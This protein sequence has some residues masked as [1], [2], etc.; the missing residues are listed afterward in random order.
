[1]LLL[2]AVAAVIVALVVLGTGP[3][4]APEL[5]EEEARPAPASVLE[6]GGTPA[7]KIS[8]VRA[9]DTDRSRDERE[10]PSTVLWPLEVGLELVRPSLLPSVPS[11]PPLG[12]G[13]TARIAGRIADSNGVGAQAELEFV[14]GP[15][16]GRVLTTGEDGR[17][18]ANDLYPGLEVVEVRGPRILGSRRE[19]RLRENKSFE[20]NIGYG[21]PGGAQGRVV[22]EQGKPIVGATVTVDGRAGVTDRT[23]HF[24]VSPVASGHSVLLEI[25]HPDYASHRAEIGVALATVAEPRR[26]LYTLTR[27][28]TLRLVLETDIG[29][30]EPALVHV[31]PQ[32]GGMNRDYPWYRLNPVQVGTEPVELTGLPAGPLELRV[33]RTGA[34]G[35]PARRR[36][37]LSA[38]GTE[39][40]ALRLAPDPLLT[41]RVVDDGQVVAGATVRVVAA[42]P[43]DASL[44]LF[45]GSRLSLEEEVLPLSPAVVRATRSAGDGRFRISAGEQVSEWRLLE[46]VGPKG[47]RRGLLAVGPNQREVEIELDSIEEG[48]AR[49]ELALPRRFQAIAVQLTI[50][51]RPGERFEVESRED[52]VIDGLAQG[53]WRLDVRWRGARLL[54]EGGLELEGVERR[55]IELPEEAILGQDRDTWLRAGR[56]WPLD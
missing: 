20:L 36:V 40:V 41:G 53:L 9:E 18:G 1:L 15:N 39:T 10:G 30:P 38:G 5:P 21:M 54:E 2:A 28:A 29:G 31:V 37:T 52:L 8:A 17:F 16:H 24:Y 34:V 12:S 11:G 6:A 19:V 35:N 25:D 26:L 22:D 33:Y 44:R 43:V 49:L 3:E 48:T 55:T 56:P 47:L 45:G 14:G 23:G 7:P 32:H 46:A 13:R 42:D 27:P 4:R 50:D 51:G